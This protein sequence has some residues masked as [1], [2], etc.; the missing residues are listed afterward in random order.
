MQAIS[1]A[2]VE[3]A[4]NEGIQC[5]NY[6]DDIVGV[7]KT[8]EQANK[9]LNRIINLLEELGI[10]ESVDKRCEPNTSIIW[11]GPKKVS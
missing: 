11:L 2:V 4:K 7:S 5:I 6:I 8:E 3:I 10:S 9:D 1:D